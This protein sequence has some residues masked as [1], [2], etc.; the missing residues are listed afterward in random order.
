M[1]KMGV[2]KYILNY[3]AIKNAKTMSMENLP[4]D[5]AWKKMHQYATT[6]AKKII[7]EIWKWVFLGV[8]IG[9]LFHGF[10]P[11]QWA[12]TL[13]SDNLFAVPM[14]VIVGV[15]LYSDEVGVIPLVEAML[16]KGVAVGTTLAFMMSIAAISLPELLILK[17]VMHWRA[18]ALLP[19]LAQQ[20]D[21]HYLGFLPIV[22]G[23]NREITHQY[24]RREKPISRFQQ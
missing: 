19:P 23:K 17:K 14:A 13:N 10:F 5:N 15:P 21:C 9:A 16:L 2:E 18:L 24:Q 4:I 3:E 11:L 22:M 20:K 1:E 12:E 6:E 8:G 7:A